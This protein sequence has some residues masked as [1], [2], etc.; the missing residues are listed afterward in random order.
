MWFISIFVAALL[1][2]SA[3]LWL[4]LPLD[5][6]RYSLTSIVA[7][8]VAVPAGIISI[9]ALVRQWYRTVQEKKRAAAAASQRDIHD[10]EKSR[11]KHLFDEALRNRR[12]SVDCRWAVTADVI[13]HGDAKPLTE[14]TE[15]TATHFYTAPS[16][17]LP[18]WP[19]NALVE[20]LDGLF[21]AMPGAITLPIA[22]CGPV[23]QAG[24]EH[25]ILVRQARQK[26]LAR[27]QEDFSKLV[28][29]DII[30]LSSDNRGV[31]AALHDIFMRRRDW[32]AIVVVAFDSRIADM[33]D[34]FD[35][36]DVGSSLSESEKWL[37]KAGRSISLLVVSQTELVDVLPKLDALGEGVSID[38][39]TPYWERQKIPA[40]MAGHLMKWPKAWRDNFASMQPIARLH[41]ASFV[42]LS[43]N[44]PLSQRAK[45][46]ESAIADAAIN[47]SLKDLDFVFEGESEAESANAQSDNRI[48]ETGWLF[49]NAGDIGYCGDRMAAM[50]LAMWQS[51]IELNP[52]DQ[53]TNTVMVVGDCGVASRYVWLALA[54]QR[55]ASDGKPVLR[56]ECAENELM[57]DFVVPFESR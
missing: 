10:A 47:A 39:L 17:A 48:T 57:A 2:W 42:E 24:R 38:S 15:Q 52:V 31:Y 11:Q 7:M 35:M 56:V 19:Q 37:G 9:W 4:V 32:P 43:D 34:S 21:N 49:H 28:L 55:I 50:S 1:G 16:P 36:V 5:I 33:A 26:V 53:A 6:F 46:T 30:Q 14:N 20:L 29:S 41:R 12:T 22:I 13:F 3:I 23:D 27:Q 40:G 18:S 54:L 8:H 25:E 44:E 45:K 51:G